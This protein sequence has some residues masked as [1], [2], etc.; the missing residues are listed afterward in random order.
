MQVVQLTLSLGRY[1][2]FLSWSRMIVLLGILVTL[3]KIFKFSFKSNLD[4]QIDPESNFSLCMKLLHTWPFN[5]MQMKHQ[6][7]KCAEN[8]QLYIRP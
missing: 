2:V 4:T 6:M 3:M 1:K 5:L 7:L 8:K